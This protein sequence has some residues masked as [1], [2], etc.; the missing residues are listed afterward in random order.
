MDASRRHLASAAIL[1]PL[2]G[3]CGQLGVL[4]EPRPYQPMRGQSG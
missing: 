3:A 2:L 4:A 1:L